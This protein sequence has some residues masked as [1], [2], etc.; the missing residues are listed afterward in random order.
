[1]NKINPPSAES[2]QTFTVLCCTTF[3]E[4]FVSLNFV[5]IPAHFISWIPINIQFKLDY[6]CN[7]LK[8]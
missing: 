8:I 5:E 7:V 2:G 6:W 3:T 1:M 4:R